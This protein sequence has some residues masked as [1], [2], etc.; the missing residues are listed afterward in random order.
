MC[1]LAGGRMWSSNAGNVDSFLL[2]NKSSQLL[3]LSAAG[4]SSW[5]ALSSGLLA[6]SDNGGWLTG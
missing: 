3:A 1:P 2:A 6:L 4:T 5:G